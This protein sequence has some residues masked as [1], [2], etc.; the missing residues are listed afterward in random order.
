MIK[1]STIDKIFDAARVEE[2]VGD[3][4]QLKK[5]GSNYKGLSPFS[6]ER[7]PSFMVSP[8]KQIWKDF[9]SGKGGNAISFIMEHEHFNYPEALKYLAKRYGIE[10]EETEQT[11][12]Q[13]QQASERESLY[14]VTDF[15]TSFFQNQLLSTEKGKAI[16]LSY[17]KER[18]FT[19]ETIEE[20]DLGYSPDEWSAFTDEALRK[21]LKL[22][23]L[24]KTGL[25]IVKGENKF[26]RFKG[27]VIFPIHSL[28][29]R[30]QGFGGRILDSQKKQAKYLNSPESDIYHK[31]KVL[32]GIYQAKKAIAKEDQCYLVEGY[33]DVIQLHQRGIKNVVASS[34]TA[35]TK[36]QIRLISRFT[37]NITVL[38]D[39]D[40]AGLRAAMRGIDIILEQDLNVKICT[41]P[42]GEDPDSFAKNHEEEEVRGFL[43]ENASDFIKFKASL[44]MEEAQG[45]P[46][47]KSELTR[48]MM[49]SVAVI[50]NE[51]RQEIYLKECSKIMDVSERVLYSTLA[52]LNAKA[53]KDAERQQKKRPP[54]NMEVV[55]KEERTAAEEIDPQYELERNLIKLL[56]LYGGQTGEFVDYVH[57]ANEEDE[58]EL[59]TE[60]HEFKVY[61]K[62][63]LELQ[64]D[65]IEFS[66]PI[67]K[68]VFQNILPQF[69]QEE[70]VKI[71]DFVK[72]LD[73][74]QAEEVSSILM[75]HDAYELHDWERKQIYV[76]DKD[77]LQ[78][79]QVTETILN[80]RC[81]LIRKK[82]AEV[83]EQL[84][85]NRGEQNIES[86]QEVMDYKQLENRIARRLKRVI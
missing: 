12:E 37:K 23:Y 57:K 54:E 50:P 11:D 76:R 38:F 41:F 46:I 4:V 69:Q 56:L 78:P 20:F 64:E 55:K 30:V 51:I 53:Q 83:M 3:F 79:Q 77:E 31:S 18:G 67:F 7:T 85:E 70:E 45:D 65:E 59:A 60:N 16:G 81:H 49:K 15:A 73:S 84:D 61:E 29:G 82:I 25:T 5:S 58:L 39:G 26:D 34:G 19:R 63:F 74:K 6:E 8:V 14:I 1:Q 43:A 36:D 71:K 42:E 17:F 33:T 44:L 66:N 28:S 32:F 62:I 80:L 68:E 21:Q 27:R 35:L 24:E 86:I 22:D 10:I 48:D 72:N 40:A 13:K 9:S 47:K 52:Q 2:V 75:Q